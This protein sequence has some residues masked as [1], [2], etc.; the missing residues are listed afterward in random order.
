MMFLCLIM[1]KPPFFQFN[2]YVVSYFW[3]EGH[4]AYKPFSSFPNLKSI[5]SLNFALLKEKPY[6][7]SGM[8]LSQD[9]EPG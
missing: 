7:A 2:A 3:P 4:V 9:D 8:A 5:A 6:C 1:T